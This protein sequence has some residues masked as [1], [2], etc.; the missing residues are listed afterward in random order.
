M[1]QRRKITSGS[2]WERR[3]KYS[4]ALVVRDMVFVSGTT[5]FDYS[6]MTVADGVEAQTRQ[7]F[8]NI[9]AALAEAGAA[10][11]DVARATYY[12]VEAKD[13]EKVLAIHA[14]VF[15]DVA[16]TSTMVVCGLI[17]ARMKIEIEVTAVKGNGP[18]RA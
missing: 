15:G 10:L 3:Y 14:Q 12:L 4:R 5:G 17:D 13:W 7:A 2:E 6:S 8:R 9:E 11:A 18:G 16:P 1:T